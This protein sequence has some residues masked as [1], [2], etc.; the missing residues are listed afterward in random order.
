MILARILQETP[1]ITCCQSLPQSQQ[2]RSPFR[3]LRPWWALGM[4]QDL[5]MQKWNR[6]EEGRICQNSMIRTCKSM[7][8]FAHK[9]PPPRE[10]RSLSAATCPI[11]LAVG[12]SLRTTL[13]SSM[14]S[15]TVAAQP[16]SGNPFT[17]WLKPL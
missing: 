6:K 5:T 3:T 9:I 2:E 14:P 15:L 8:A 13:T 1:S 11:P 16:S 17:A 4:G 12:D 10:Q 7:D